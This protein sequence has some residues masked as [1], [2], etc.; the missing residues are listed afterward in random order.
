[1]TK[2]RARSDSPETAPDWALEHRRHV[3]LS[4]WVPVTPEHRSA[5][6]G[7]LCSGLPMFLVSARALTWG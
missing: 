7:D 1:M 3:V 2:A 6:P 4:L 5:I